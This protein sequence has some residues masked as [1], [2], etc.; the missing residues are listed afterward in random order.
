MELGTDS[1]KNL[2][3]GWLSRYIKSFHS[4]TI[5]PAYAIGNTPPASLLGSMEQINI[6]EVKD[7]KMD[8]NESLMKI[9][10]KMYSEGKSSVHYSGVSALQNMEHI[11]KAVKS[12]VNL[13]NYTPS[14]NA[15]YMKEW[16]GEDLA[17]SLK[18][19]AQLIK[20]DIGMKVAT[21]DYDGWDMHDGQEWKFAKWCE[22]L[23]RN[24]TAFYND[25]YVYDKKVTVVVMSEFGRRLKPNKNGGTDH[26]HGGL[27]MVLGGNVN[28]GNIYG[29][30]PGL[31]NEQ[32]DNG[33]DLAVTTD[34]R[35]VL[36]EILQKRNLVNSV[37]DIFPKFQMTA[38]LGI[39][40]S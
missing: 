33:V 24:L 18:A 21:V 28:G 35:T 29:K 22:S 25:I 40:K 12:S 20:M 39:V 31:A 34:Y 3:N 38:G 23:S 26:G 1:D 7:L 19:V 6:T 5:V 13:E 32:L 11:K 16:P 9:L 14:S 37:S 17:K 30:W 27:M 8:L 4:G 10:S 36:A 2:S 15:N